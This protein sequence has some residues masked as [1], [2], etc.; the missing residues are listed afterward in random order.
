MFNSLV[1]SSIFFSDSLFFMTH[2][3]IS[4]GLGVCD[5]FGPQHLAPQARG[6]PAAHVSV[7]LGF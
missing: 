6:F 7:I 3:V 2:C 1:I 4:L 5:F